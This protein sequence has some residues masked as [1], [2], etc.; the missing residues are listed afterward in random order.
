MEKNK[1]REIQ[2]AMEILK[3]K[4]I[5]IK[6]EHDEELNMEIVTITH[7]DAEVIVYFGNDDSIKNGLGLEED[8][9]CMYLGDNDLIQGIKTVDGTFYLANDDTFSDCG[10]SGART[11]DKEYMLNAIC[12]FHEDAAIFNE[13]IK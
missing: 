10:L 1:E 6:A 4:E 7:R 9:V 3:G 11:V 2:E 12:S 8:I 13:I 5:D